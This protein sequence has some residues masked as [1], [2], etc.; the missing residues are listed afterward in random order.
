[1][2]TLKLINMDDAAHEYAISVSGLEGLELVATRNPV[3]VESGE[4]A[5]MPVRVR[6]DPYALPETSN[7]I[8]FH[9]EAVDDASMAK[10]TEARFLG[11]APQ[12]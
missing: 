11:P 7:S 8:A 6:V 12:R 9:M 4:V 3:R 1:M 10:T 5:E 2:Y